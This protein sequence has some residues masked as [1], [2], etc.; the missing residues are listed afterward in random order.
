[1]A[2]ELRREGNWTVDRGVV[3]PA[4]DAPAHLRQAA[5]AAC[6]NG[7]TRA[8]LNAGPTA[9]REAL[10]AQPQ[11]EDGLAYAPGQIVVTGGAKAAIFNAFA[12]TLSVD[13]E[14]LFPAPY[15]VS[16]P[17]MILACDG[18]PVTLACPEEHQF[19]L[20]AAKLRHAHTPRHRWL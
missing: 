18:R 8:T 6:V 17:D 10:A 9:L 15:W 14:V 12:A 11:R 16:Y 3:E 1:P 19:K 5:G 2:S 7:E 20:T 13:D 4:F